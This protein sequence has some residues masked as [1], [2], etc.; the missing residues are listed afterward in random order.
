MLEV[1]STV[2]N[3]R[4]H[5]GARTI[6]APNAPNG[7][8]LLHVL[9]FMNHAGWTCDRCRWCVWPGFPFFYCDLLS[10]RAMNVASEWFASVERGWAGD[11]L[12]PGKAICRTSSLRNF[13]R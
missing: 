5:G 13:S 10:V 8:A 1:P 7:P 9:K 3:R 4:F 11:V 6:H 2:L 12:E